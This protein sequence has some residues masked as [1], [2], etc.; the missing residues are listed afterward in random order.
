[1]ISKDA[2]KRGNPFIEFRQRY[3]LSQDELAICL[4]ISRTNLNMMENNK[5]YYSS[6]LIKEMVAFI[7]L[8]YKINLDEERGKEERYCP[9]MDNDTYARE[10]KDRYVFLKNEVEHL[11]QLEEQ[12]FRLK[13]AIEETVNEPGS[14]WIVTMIKRMKKIEKELG[15]DKDIKKLTLEYYKK[16]LERIGGLKKEKE[17]RGKA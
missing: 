15:I 3:G 1:M 14:Y 10:C 13:K 6:T 11:D 4:K 12:Y 16:E 9:A 7:T 2:R 8:S 5:R 17:T